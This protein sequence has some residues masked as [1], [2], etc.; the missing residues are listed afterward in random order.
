MHDIAMEFADEASFAS[1]K[2]DLQTARLFLG[3]ALQLEKTF[4]LSLPLDPEF[5]LTR[6]VMMRS[7]ATLAL[8]YGDAKEAV[9]LATTCL[10]QNP[11]PAITEDLN[12]ILQRA[13]KVQTSAP[14]SFTFTGVLVSADIPNSLIKIQRKSDRQF[15]TVR[16]PQDSIE[17][18]VK[19]YWAGLVRI[20]GK[21]NPGGIFLLEKIRKAA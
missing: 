1:R 5:Q 18:M 13:G 9:N 8:E 6:S 20:E 7:A 21:Q 2:G 11:H 10:S 17:S 16:V 19:K 15:F 12:E 4:A 3:K 14:V